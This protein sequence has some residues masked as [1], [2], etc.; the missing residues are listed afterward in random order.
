MRMESLAHRSRVFISKQAPIIADRTIGEGIRNV[1]RQ[2]K[3]PERYAQSLH[4][5][6]DGETLWC[7]VDFE[8][9]DPDARG[10]VAPLGKFF[11]EGTK[12]H[13]IAP[14]FK[15]ALHWIQD[16]VGRFSMGHWVRGIAARHVFKD[17]VR[18]GIKKFNKELERE[19]TEHLERTRLR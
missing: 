7:W 14:V 11:E 9:R 8:A 6:M 3:M 13:F 2:R 10:D 18:Q 4:F 12:R 19:L 15:K 1:A 16:G 17:G 5:E